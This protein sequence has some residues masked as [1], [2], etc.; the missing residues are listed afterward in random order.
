MKAKENSNEFG[1]TLT[2]C[3]PI[4]MKQLN[5]SRSNNNVDNNN[6]NNR[7]QQTTSRGRLSHIPLFNSDLISTQ[8]S[9]FS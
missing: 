6:N 2:S 1:A 7:Q 5:S 3:G 4:L 9:I 8:I